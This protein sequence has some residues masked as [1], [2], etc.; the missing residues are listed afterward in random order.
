M[1][2]SQSSET[3]GF[4]GNSGTVGFIGRQQ[5]QTATA[6][7]LEDADR[8][9]KADQADQRKLQ[10][11]CLFDAASQAPRT[12]PSVQYQKQLQSSAVAA[13][14]RRS[15]FSAPIRAEAFLLT[16]DYSKLILACDSSSCRSRLLA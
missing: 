11:I 15:A 6:T 7:A 8:A 4:S 9:K 14:S 16:T 3:V 1:E 2:I 5:Q 12:I 10:L 13:Y